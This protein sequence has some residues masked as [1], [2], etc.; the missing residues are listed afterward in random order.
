MQVV[1]DASDLGERFGGFFSTLAQG[2]KEAV[3]LQAKDAYDRI[4]TGTYWTNRTGATRKTFRV[5][6]ASTSDGA[7]STVTSANKVATFLD[8]GTKAHEI[9]ARRA[10]MLV[11]FW[12]KMGRMFYGKK[13]NHPGTQATNF[14]AKEEFRGLPELL[15]RGDV[16]VESALRNAGLG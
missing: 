5:L 11:F 14:V 1:L 15:N 10:P 12:A 6:A 13:V 3:R 2:S 4:V 9:R 16:A 8:K 7:S